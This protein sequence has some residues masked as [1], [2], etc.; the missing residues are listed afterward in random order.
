MLTN[1]CRDAYVCRQGLLGLVLTPGSV[2]LL[3]YHLE[4]DGPDPDYAQ[5]MVATLAT[6]VAQ[7]RGAIVN[8]YNV[9]SDKL[10]D[11]ICLTNVIVRD[12]CD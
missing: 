4:S 8:H 10:R 12:S 3:P 5:V 6:V 2:V 1:H 7:V 11:L 9:T